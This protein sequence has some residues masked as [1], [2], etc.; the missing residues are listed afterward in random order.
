MAN[1]VPKD[2]FVVEPGSCSFGS[3]C[4][5]CIRVDYPNAEG[6][7]EHNYKIVSDRGVYRTLGAAQAAAD[8]IE[9]ES[10]TEEGVITLAPPLE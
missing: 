9:V 2:K 8:D 6:E 1:L 3:D 4:F 5:P 10:V 7:I